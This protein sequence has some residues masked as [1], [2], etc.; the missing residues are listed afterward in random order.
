MP[1]DWVPH[2]TKGY[3]QNLNGSHYLSQWYNW[4]IW[5][6]IS[7]LVVNRI[8]HI[9]FVSPSRHGF[10]KIVSDEFDKGNVREI[11]QFTFGPFEAWQCIRFLIDHFPIM[12][13]QQA[14]WT[15]FVKK[16]NFMKIDIY[17]IIQNWVFKKSGFLVK[18]WKT[19]TFF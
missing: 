13:S 8:Y 4:N 5:L 18:F 19:W 14:L 10:I 3:W 15:I 12:I 11:N 7:K 17:K 16:E 2:R 9:M 6:F 1:L